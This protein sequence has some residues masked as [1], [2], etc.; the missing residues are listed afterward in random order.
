MLEENNARQGFLDHGGFL[1]LHRALPD[2]IKDPIAFLY[3]SG[4][5]VS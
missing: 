5:H 2:W 1:A 4:W 3:L